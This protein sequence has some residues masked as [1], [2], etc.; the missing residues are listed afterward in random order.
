MKKE[1]GKDEGKDGGKTKKAKGG[2]GRSEEQWER[3]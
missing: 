2:D 3:P 1:E